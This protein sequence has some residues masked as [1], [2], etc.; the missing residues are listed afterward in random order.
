MFQSTTRSLIELKE[1]LLALGVTHV[2]EAPAF[3]GNI[4]KPGDFSI[5]VVNARHIKY[6]PGHKTD[7][8]DLAW[9]FFAPYC[10]KAASFPVEYGATFAS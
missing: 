5:M 9:I 7:K 3:T 8:K 6:V 10:S 4:F 1:W 2:T